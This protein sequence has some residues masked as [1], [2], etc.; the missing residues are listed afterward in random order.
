MIFRSCKIKQHQSCKEQTQG[1]SQTLKGTSQGFRYRVTVIYSYTQLHSHSLKDQ[2][3]EPLH[4]PCPTGEEAKVREVTDSFLGAELLALQVCS[5][6]WGPCEDSILWDS[7]CVPGLC[8]VGCYL[9]HKWANQEW[10]F[11]TSPQSMASNHMRLRS[12]DSLLSCAFYHQSFR[13]QLLTCLIQA[14]RYHI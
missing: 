1:S 5:C 6:P 8:H 2:T 7:Q 11:Y 9:G 14:H 10:G 4:S 3:W 13:S 12:L